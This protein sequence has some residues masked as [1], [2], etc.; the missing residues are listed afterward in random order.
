MKKKLRPPTKIHGGKFYLSSWVI[1]YFPKDY[2]NMTYLEPFCGAA[3]VFL[4]KERSR[5]EILN[6]VDEGMIK[7]FWALR[8]EPNEFIGRLK[9][10]KYCESTFERA[11]KKLEKDATVDYLDGAVNEYIVRRMSRGGLKTAFAWSERKRGG[12]PGD[13][14]AWETMVQQLPDL[15]ERIK[16]TYVLNKNALEILKAFNDPDTLVY[17][18][19]P[20]LDITRTSPNAYEYEMTEDDHIELATILNSFKGKVLL[21]GYSSA[22]YRRL[23]NPE[24]GWKCRRK[25]IAN[26][27]SQTKSKAIK[28][29]CL[30]CNFW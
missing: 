1:S 3:S 6:D 26:H 30:W 11:Q 2:E 29:E 5:E 7:I 22:L 8:D 9:R 12:K 10:I 13:V 24:T 23:F 19:P 17:C 28:T 15:A 20:Y 25:R 4:N 27:S 14:N 16:G 18:D 21:S